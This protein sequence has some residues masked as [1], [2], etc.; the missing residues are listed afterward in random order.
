MKQKRV[1]YTEM[2]Y[3]V[4]ILAMAVGNSLMERADLGLSMVVAPAYLLHL[5]ISQIL[6]WFS[7]GVSEYI[8]Q[9]FLLALL[10]AFMKSFKRNYLFSFVTAVLYGCVLDICI[11]LITI[12]SVT[13]LASR[14]CCYVFGML[15]GSFGVSM[16]FHTYF[17]MEAYDLIVKEYVGKYNGNIGRVKTIYDCCSCLLAILLSFLFFGMWHFEGI[18]IG[19][20]ICA[21]V[22]GSL[23]GF[24]SRWLDALFYFE[25]CLP[26]RS[27]FEK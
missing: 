26:L 7:F 3:V 18:K 23:I 27:T 10:G 25:D 8:F 16:M 13:N 19:T 2:A 15:I 14:C 21:L 5:K 4:G 11:S 20:V 24:H 1:F 17:S 22:N 12:I 9:A 6:P